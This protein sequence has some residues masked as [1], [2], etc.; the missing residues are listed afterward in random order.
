MS[1]NFEIL[2]SLADIELDKINRSI[3][4]IKERRETIQKHKWPRRKRNINV[5][6]EHRIHHLKCPQDCP[7][8]P[9]AIKINPITL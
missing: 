9:F 4:E 8:R 2:K 3:K 5:C 6:L 1:E 7:N